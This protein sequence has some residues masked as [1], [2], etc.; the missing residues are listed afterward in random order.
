MGNFP[1]F[2]TF[3]QLFEKLKSSQEPVEAPLMEPLTYDIKSV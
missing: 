1:K 2:I 3:I